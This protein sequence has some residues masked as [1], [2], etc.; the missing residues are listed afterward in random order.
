MGYLETVP[1]L[2]PLYAGADYVE[3]KTIEGSAD[4]RRFIAG[5]MRRP[6]WLGALFTLR[7]ILVRPFGIR[8][9]RVEGDG[10]RPEDVPFAPG[11]KCRGF[12]VTCGREGE[13]LAMHID[14]PHLKAQVIVAAVPLPLGG[15]RFHVATIVHYNNR[16]G[17]IY[18]SI[19]L[20]FHH[21]VVESMM[22]KGAKA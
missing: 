10:L 9:E 18:F 13:H 19:I 20:P 5:M 12:T 17:P 7:K 11:E 4:L 8:Q 22:R 15:N 6:T 2:A 16:L 21:L 3:E 1:E 14:D